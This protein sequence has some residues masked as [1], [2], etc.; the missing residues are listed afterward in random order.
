M[1]CQELYPRIVDAYTKV[2]VVRRRAYAATPVVDIFE[3]V[4]IK[5]FAAPRSQSL[6]AIVHTFCGVLYAKWV[7]ADIV[8]IHAVG[9]GLMVPLARLLRMKVVFTHHGED[10]NR[11]K[12]GWLARCLLRLGE[13]LAVRYAHR[14][15]VISDVLLEEMKRKYPRQTHLALI[16]NGVQI[17]Q[18]EESKGDDREILKQW[19]LVPQ[20]YILS[21]GRIVEEKGF[22]R[23]AQAFIEV[24]PKFL[25]LVIA[26][27]IAKNDRYTD[28]LRTICRKDDRIVMTGAVGHDKLVPL[29]RYARLFVLP[30]LHEGLPIALLEAMAYK[31]PVLVSDIPAHRAMKLPDGSYFAGKAPDALVKAL[32]KR[33]A[34]GALKRVAYD[35]STYNW[36]NIATQTKNIYEDLCHGTTEGVY[37]EYRNLIGRD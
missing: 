13:R 23:L 26:G 9:P 27:G 30:S 8:H 6:E 33:L 18:S 24:A 32:H 2:T 20:N 28:K 36:R 31:C 34:Q 35:M 17:R 15:I 25:K 21:V 7:K 12:W 5:D 16:P 1:H 14:V 3:G 10:Y 4:E 29:Y 37:T 19:S 22:D 11:A